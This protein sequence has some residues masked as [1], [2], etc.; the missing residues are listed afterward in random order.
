MA[1][2]SESSEQ[3]DATLAFGGEPSEPVPAEEPVIPPNETPQT[4][5]EEYPEPPGEI[6]PETPPE[7]P[8][9]PDEVPPAPP[10]EALPGR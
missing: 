1:M 9:S 6:P 10:P 3:K 2:Q 4:P 7:V 8:H 5:P